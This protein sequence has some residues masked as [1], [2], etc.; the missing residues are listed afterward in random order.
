MKFLIDAH[1]HTVASGHAFSTLLEN[2]RYAKENGLEVMAVT[3]HA[4]TIPG[5]TTINHFYN[6][7]VIP[8]VI[9]GIQ[10]LRGIEANIID[11]EGNID[12]PDDLLPHL[13]LV[14]AS[15]HDICIEPG[16]KEENTRSVLRAMDNKYIDIFGHLGNPI[17]EIDIDAVV[18]KAKEKNKLIEINNS[19]FV[20]S[21]IGS[22][23]NCCII[24]KKVMDMGGQLIL[25]S[26]AHICF[27]VGK[28]EK[29]EQLIREVGIPEEMIM[30]VSVEKFKKYLHDKGKIKDII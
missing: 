18:K 29:A 2:V 9:D 13:D 21:R 26:D 22:Y 19:S 10:V 30:N 16:S 12:V 1:T 5:A 17:F 27:N 14:I 25:G 6:L 4:P 23:E 11:Y 20:S 24:A 3:D 28:F 8:R 7:K 15:F